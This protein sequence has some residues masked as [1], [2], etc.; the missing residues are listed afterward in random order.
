MRKQITF[1]S[2]AIIFLAASCK[3]SS[4]NPV[5]TIE[6]GQIVGVETPTEGVT[7][8]RGIPYAAPPVGDLRW[9]EPQPVVAWDSIKVADTFGAPSLQAKHN[10]GDFY[11]KEFFFDGD[12]EYSEDCLFLNIWT[13]AASKTDAK[14]PVAMWIH[15]GAFTGGWGH[16][17]EMDGEAWAER[18]V[19]LVTIN[20]R[21]GIFGFMAHPELSAESE[22]HVS[23]NYGI[24]DQLA[25]IKWIRR[26]IEQFG[27]DPEQITIFGQSAGAMS[28][29]TL[30]ASP[31]VDGLIKGAIIQSG[32]GL[33]QSRHSASLE[34][35][36]T[37]GKNFSDFAN[38]QSIADMRNA[39]YSE[40]VEASKK[41]SDETQT[42]LILSPIIDNYLSPLSFDSAA[43]ANKITN[44]HYMIGS[45]TDDIRGLDASLNEFCFNREEM[46]KYPAYQ[47]RFARKMP[48]D[49][50]GAFHSSELWYIFHTTELCWR[51]LV[52]ADVTLS[53]RMVDNWTNFVKYGNPNDENS[54]QWEPCT[55][56][57]P[58][59]EQFNIEQ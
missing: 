33:G 58:Y 31:L 9:K 49:E 12:P 10:V 22:H 13:P 1:L 6:G 55:R 47:Y 59:I 57:N 4:Q 54:N 11:Q 18:G 56:N 29:K 36:E 27:G 14:L 21:L 40:L 44:I 3:Q 8:Y 42:R 15:G 32:G 16:E 30:I 25:A 51:P 28:V 24:L 2:L 37:V 5:L 43:M 23:G 20:Y 34:A 53:D 48:G 52:E 17:P 35:A 46:G 41:F 50:A 19:I 45:T 26:N 39:S 7:V 38:Y